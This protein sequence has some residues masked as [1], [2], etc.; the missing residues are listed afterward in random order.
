MQCPSGGWHHALGAGE[1]AG[2]RAYVRMLGASSRLGSS[3][4]CSLG[5]PSRQQGRTV[6]VRSS[7]RLTD[8][9]HLYR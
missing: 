8:A 7:V 9:P 2:R 6:H 1:V 3:R 5:C 4:F